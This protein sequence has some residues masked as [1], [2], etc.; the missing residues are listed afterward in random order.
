MDAA[1]KPRAERSFR[2]MIAR[3]LLYS[4]LALWLSFIGLFEHYSQTRPT[5]ENL[6]EGRTYKQNNHGYYTYLTSGEHSR[7]RI[8][9]IVAPVLFLVGSLVDPERR[10]WRWRRSTRTN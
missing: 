10:M 1:K 4:S 9:G 7:L 8:L 3:I 5:V 2:V 6:S